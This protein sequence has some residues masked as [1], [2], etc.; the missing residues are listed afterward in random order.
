MANGNRFFASAMRGVGRP[1]PGAGCRRRLLLSTAAAFIAVPAVASSKTSTSDDYTK[2]NICTSN[3]T[4]MTDDLKDAQYTSKSGNIFVFYDDDNGTGTIKLGSKEKTAVVTIDSSNYVYSNGYM[5]NSGASNA[6]GIRVDLSKD[7]DVSAI[8]S[9][10][11]NGKARTW[12]ILNYAGSEITGAAIYLDEAAD[13]VLSGDGANKIGIWVDPS[14]SATGTGTLTGDI[15]TYSGSVISVKG[16]NSYGLKMDE[17]ATLKG[18]IKLEGT[19]TLYQH[20]AKGKDYSGLYG[21][22]LNGYVN[23]DAGILKGGSVVAYGSGAVGML[24]AG[25]GIS[26]DL[27]VEGAL[28]TQ[29]YYSDSYTYSYKRRTYANAGP[30]LIVGSD[31][32]GGIYVSGARYKSDTGS[33]SGSITAGTNDEAVL[34]DPAHGVGAYATPE[35]LVMGLYDDTYDPGFSFY[36]RGSISAAPTNVN[37]KVDAAVKIVGGASSN[38]PTV[39]T[40][41][42]YNSGSISASAT[43]DDSDGDNPTTSAT[44]LYLDG[45]VYVGGTYNKTTGTYT[46]D[47]VSCGTS[48]GTVTC[49]YNSGGLAKTKNEDDAAALV[50][51]GETGSGTISAAI[52]GVGGGTATALYISADSRLSSIVNS[53]KI[54]AGASTTKTDTTQPLSAY[55]IQDKSGTLTY[56]YNHGGTISATATTLD[57]NDETAV[58]IDLS[59][60]TSASNSYNGVTILDEAKSDASAAISGDILFGAGNNQVISVTGAGSSYV[61][62]I[63]GDIKFGTDSTPGVADDNG[64][65]LY[66]NAFGV[67]SARISAPSGISVDVANNGILYLTNS[68]IKY[69]SDKLAA[70]NARKVTV[71]SGGTLTVGVTEEMKSQL[72]NGVIVAG[73][74]VT[75]E[76]NSNLGLSFNSYLKG[77]NYVLLST[78][79]GDLNVADLATYGHNI[80]TPISADTEGVMP[81]LF[82]SASLKYA[83][84]SGNLVEDESQASKLVLSVQMKTKD[85]LGLT[86]YGYQMF[87]QINTALVNDDKLGAAM[88]SGIHADTTDKKAEG[89]S[90]EAQKAYDSFAPNVTGGTRAIAVSITDQATGAV[91]A[92]QRSLRLYGKEEG[93]YTLWAQEFVQSIKDPGRG[94]VQADKTRE[95]NGFKDH[96]FGVVLGMDAGN[97]HDGWLGG[98]LT[99]YSGDVNEI[100]RSSHE[101]QIWTVATGYGSWRGKGLFV[102][103]K[104]DL[105]YAHIKGTRYIQLYTGTGTSQ[106][107]YSRY[108]QNSHAA[109]LLSGG[110]TAGGMFT[111]GALTAAPQISLDGMVLREEGFTEHNPLGTTTNGDAFNL[112]VESYYA[113]SLRSFLGSDLRYDI[114]VKNLYVQPE[115]RL[116]Y[117]YDFLAD[118]VKLKA[119]FK[120]IDRD[121][122]GN[123]TGQEF[124]LTGPDPSRG[125]AVLGATLGLSTAD[126]GLHF[127][128]DY[129]RGTNGIVEQVATFNLIGRI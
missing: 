66:V 25:K 92:R 89:T 115:I 96:G 118:A 75:M 103:G 85:E 46:P 11:S 93:D 16:N 19:L 82:K 20:D 30:A 68:T 32:A 127:N 28:T 12:E 64:D 71:K 65:H 41:G 34:I 31:V 7:I 63:S 123:Q 13:M 81:F 61:A 27:T 33:T 17:G 18:D 129:V 113:K 52:S 87:D 126:W 4:C 86:G 22:S 125:N 78:P 39:I 107:A 59:A 2:D 55:A 121:T 111:Y 9:V 88:I 48:G 110:F 3:I 67:V 109:A 35:S 117:R 83:D 114:K 24:V 36:N 80:S 108:A 116:G 15:I 45:Y 43:T 79:A 70:L 128:Y 72:P 26:G 97:P 60:G 50:N 42:L 73:D 95:Q 54:A 14:G 124:S 47:A 58:A 38:L 56:I 44:G 40:G 29:G 122:A 51:S 62:T 91:A 105:G 37:E 101:T 8:R 76:T 99:F 57:G 23:G 77:G 69:S 1:K 10:D 49:T 94:A 21:V 102:D 6:Y 106:T 98:A 120:D 100:G 112:K 74:K 5:T 90:R 53:G 119:A 84:A 104:I